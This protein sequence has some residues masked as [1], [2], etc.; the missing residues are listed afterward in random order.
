MALCQGGAQHFVNES[1]GVKDLD[2]RAFFRA[3]PE[4]AFPPRANLEPGFRDLTSRTAPSR[5]RVQRT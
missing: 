2:V 4:Q 3:H 5:Y 1:H